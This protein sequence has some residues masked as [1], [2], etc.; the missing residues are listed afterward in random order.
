SL[1]PDQIAGKFATSFLKYMDGKTSE[2]LAEFTSQIE[3]DS[4]FAPSYFGRGACYAENKETYSQAMKDYNKAIELRGKIAVFYY[5]RGCLK[6]DLG[7]KDEAIADYKKAIEIRK[8]YAQ[9]YVNIGVVQ[10]ENNEYDAALTNFIIG[11]DLEPTLPNVY[12]NIALI[13]QL[14]EKW[15]EACENFQKAVE[16]G[17]KAKKLKKKACK[18]ACKLKCSAT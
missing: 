7:K 16:L 5:N 2:A 15:Q 11:R 12:Y 6:S 4:T 18:K 8:D 10:F 9:A 13:Y 3:Q 17:I 14:K 1:A